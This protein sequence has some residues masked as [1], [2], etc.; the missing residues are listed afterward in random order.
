MMSSDECLSFEHNVNAFQNRPITHVG[1]T[2]KMVVISRLLSR[3]SHQSQACVILRPPDILI[4]HAGIGLAACQRRAR[5]VPLQA[6]RLERYG[7]EGLP[8]MWYPLLPCSGD[9]FA[10]RGPQRAS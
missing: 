6:A 10:P 1:A 7:A 2:E 4:L 9:Q 8:G 5:A 3:A